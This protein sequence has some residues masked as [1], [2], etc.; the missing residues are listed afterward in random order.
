MKKLIIILLCLLVTPLMAQDLSNIIRVGREL[1]NQLLD[2]MVI[3]PEQEDSIG[4]A[5][6]EQLTRELSIANE[7]SSD[8][9]LQLIRRLMRSMLPYIEHRDINYDIHLVL[10]DNTVNAFAIAGGH[11]Y[12][13]T[14]ML[15]WVDSEDELACII[16]HEMGHVDKKH[17]LRKVKKIMFAEQITG[18]WAPIVLQAQSLIT[19]PFGQ[20]DEFEADRVGVTFASQAGY[21]PWAALVSFQRIADTEGDHQTDDGSQEGIGG[22]IQSGLEQWTRTHPPG[23]ARKENVRRHIE[24][25]LQQGNR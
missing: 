2:Q 7:S 15:D 14:G 1:E 21:N 23:A 25:N 6:H 17:C 13:I 10:D 18:D 20:E 12:I 5:I 19:M 24:E 4:D 22:Q 3:S 11:I 16:G 8:P 9:R